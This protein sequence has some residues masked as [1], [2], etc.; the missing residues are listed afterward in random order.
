VVIGSEF[1]VSGDPPP[2]LD[3]I[4]LSYHGQSCMRVYIGSAPLAAI[5]NMGR[6]E[7]H[8]ARLA[9]G[10]APKMPEIH[11]EL[12]YD[13]N[14]VVSTDPTH[15]RPIPTYSDLGAPLPGTDRCPPTA[16]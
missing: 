15:P 13:L 5:A 16:G 6:E 7:T 10:L 3:K 14:L 9:A 11:F 8:P 2:P 12:Y 1:I 4:L